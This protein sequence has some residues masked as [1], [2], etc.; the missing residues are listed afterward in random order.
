[1]KKS[2]LAV[3]AVATLALTAGTPAHAQRG[4]AAGVAAG[5]IGGAIVGARWRL[6]IITDQAPAIMNRAI[7]RPATT[8]RVRAMSPTTITA[9]AASGR[10]SASGTA[11]PGAS[12]AS[13]SAAKAT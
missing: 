1:M 12:A 7:T 8:R 6:R 9:A 3:A 13:E 11:T 10:S 2:L 5:I 4:V